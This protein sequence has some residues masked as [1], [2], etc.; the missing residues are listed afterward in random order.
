[1]SKKIKILLCVIGIFLVTSILIGISYAYYIFNVS[2][3]GS[4]ALQT[5][6]FRVTYTDQNPIN[7][8]NTIPMSDKE[9]KEELT[10]YTFTINNV[11]NHAIDYDVNIE[12]L[13]GS[14]IDLN[15]VRIRLN[16][17]ESQIL[18]DI[19]DNNSSVI[20]NHNVLSSKTIKHGSIGANG[21]K[22]YNLRMYIDEDSTIDE[23]ANKTFSS[24]VVVSTKLNPDYKEAVL[25]YG[26]SFNIVIKRLSGDGNP[27][28]SYSN[29]SI[30]SIQRSLTMPNETDN[31]ENVEFYNSDIPIYVWFKDGVIYIYSDTDKIYLNSDSRSIFNALEALVDIDLSM[32]DTSKVTNMYEMFG[33]TSSVLSLDLSGFD[34]SN[35][36]NMWNMFYNMG[37]ITELDLSSFDTSN[38]TNMIQMFKDDVLLSNII[39]GDDW[40]T[41]NVVEMDQMFCSTNLSVYDLSNFDFL[42]TKSIMGMLSDNKSGASIM[43]GDNFDTSR[44]ENFQQLFSNSFY[45]N[46]DLSYFDTSSALNM[47]SMFSDSYYSEL[48][49]SSFDTSNVTNFNYMFSGMQN[50]T[51]LDLSSF[52]IGSTETAKKMFSNIPLLETVYVSEKWNK[53]DNFYDIYMFEYDEKLKGGAGTSFSWALAGADSAQIDCGS[54]HPGF[55]TYK[56]SLG[57]NLAYCKSIGYDY[58]LSN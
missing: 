58:S 34:T 43:F 39:Y 20:V 51:E 8:S 50:L 44:V 32:F 56:G 29:N 38:V 12:T 35:V 10:P 31:Y 17:F 52:D 30:T 49:L 41:T 42:N 16:N 37:S 13:E 53:T 1:M 18:G 57:D 19:E 5:D 27:Q 4:N 54:E 6:C 26:D 14:T 7:L 3:S 15:A 28:T 22:K 40:N 2:Q 36:T 25:T 46:L 45:S 11:C 48:D 21:T 33:N 23:S 47:H 9:A 24:K 55:F